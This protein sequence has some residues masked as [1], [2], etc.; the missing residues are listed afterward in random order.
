MDVGIEIRRCRRVFRRGDVPLLARVDRSEERN[1]ADRVHP[2]GVLR[3]ESVERSPAA[4]RAPGLYV[5]CACAPAGRGR[6]AGAGR[7]RGSSGGVGRGVI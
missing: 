2:A 6:P 4:A 7:R 3:E 5:G 1:A